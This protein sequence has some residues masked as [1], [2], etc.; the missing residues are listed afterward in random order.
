MAP[1]PRHC[2]LQRHAGRDV[3]RRLPDT[4]VLLPASPTK[5]SGGSRGASEGMKGKK[6]LGVKEGCRV[7]CPRLCVGM[8]SA[9]LSVLLL[10]VGTQPACPRKA[11]GMAP[12]AR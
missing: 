11:V 10:T 1:G 3:L 6:T 8:E 5:R 4:G 7:P 12:G 2:R 9:F